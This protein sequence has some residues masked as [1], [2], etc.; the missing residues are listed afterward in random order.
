M[1]YLL[2]QQKMVQSDS[3]CIRCG[4]VRVF[5]KKWKEK[6][7]GKGP[8]LF[9]IESVCPDPECQKIVDKKFEEMREKRLF[10]EEKRSS[11]SLAKRTKIS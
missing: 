10:S 9:H 5:S 4:K 2:A 8:M 7:D 3:L 6:V 11:V 1:V